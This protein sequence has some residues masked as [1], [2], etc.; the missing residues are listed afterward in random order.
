M[1]DDGE[2]TF[3][4][5]TLSI[6]ATLP[7]PN[8]IQYILKFHCQSYSLIC[9]NEVIYNHIIKIFLSVILCN[10]RKMFLFMINLSNCTEN[11][12]FVISYIYQVV[13]QHS[14]IAHVW[15]SMLTTEGVSLISD[16]YKTYGGVSTKIFGRGKYYLITYMSSILKGLA[17]PV[18]GN[19]DLKM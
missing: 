4:I 6:V 15:A 17:L 14:G 1:S 18:K 2:H 12:H 8:P 19:L 7:L 5:S 11:I 3:C 10:G 13:E 9:I 16:W